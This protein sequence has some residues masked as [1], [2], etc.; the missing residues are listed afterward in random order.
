MS[1][2]NPS[3]DPKN[4]MFKVLALCAAL[5]P[6]VLSACA[7]ESLENLPATFGIVEA[8]PITLDIAGMN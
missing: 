6:F 5:V 4:V 1:S 8:S 7:S 3:L 2:P